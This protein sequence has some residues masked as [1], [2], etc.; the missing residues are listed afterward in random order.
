MK[1]REEI[2]MKAPL[3]NWTPITLRDFES[4]SCR[5]INCLYHNEITTREAAKDAVESG[6]LSLKRTR[7]YGKES[8][9]ELCE[10][11]GIEVP[12]KGG[13]AWKFDPWTGEKK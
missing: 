7:N 1:N 2:E 10:F 9:R 5:L 8:E 11:L 6:R 4:V 3:A 13:R 12:A